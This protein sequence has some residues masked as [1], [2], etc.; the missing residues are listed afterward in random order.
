MGTS[1]NRDKLKPGIPLLPD[2]I[3]PPDDE[4][5]N[6]PPN[7]QEDDSPVDENGTQDED[8][9]GEERQPSLE[10][11][12]NEVQVANRYLQSQRGFRKA[13][14]GT[15]I[16]RG[17]I[18]RVLKNYISRAGGGPRTMTRRMGRSSGAIARFGEV[19]TNIQQSGQENELRR[20]QLNTYIGRPA[21]EVLSALMN[22]V[23]TIGALLDD[24]VTNQAY[25]NTVVRIDAENPG[26]D[27]DNLNAAQIAEML[28]TFLEETIVC[29]LIC[30][31][32]RSLTV[33]TSDVERS[34]Q[35]EQTLYQ[36]VNG[37]VHSVVIP[38]LQ[39]SLQNPMALRQE[40]DSI[41][42]IAFSTIVQ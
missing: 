20:L 38:R 42:E 13:V 40:M 3:L 15:N 1:A 36:V 22:V 10:H 23:C 35:I 5:G 14:R 9:E 30:D 18:T 11:G 7:E 25:A 32:G 12:Q 4:Q 29:R 8:N 17:L 41:Y 2:W 26:L 33:A 28:A 31:V 16:D 34:R 21:L 27:L 6:N 24:A 19:L 39:T 37:L